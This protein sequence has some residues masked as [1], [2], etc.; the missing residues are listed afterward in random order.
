M[1][2]TERPGGTGSCSDGPIVGGPSSSRTRR[3]ASQGPLRPCPV[4][5]LLFAA[6]QARD[7]AR[8]HSRVAVFWPR[9]SIGQQ[10]CANGALLRKPSASR[11]RSF[12]VDLRCRFQKRIERVASATRSWYRFATCHSRCCGPRRRTSRYK[13][14]SDRSR[15][16][17]DLWWTTQASERSPPFSF[18]NVRDRTKGRRPHCRLCPASSSVRPHVASEP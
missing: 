2:R 6:H 7:S 11:H 17:V 8:A 9:L 4:R 14:R 5:A 1:I 3:E 15:S 12:D 13:R 18:C 10:R 16:I